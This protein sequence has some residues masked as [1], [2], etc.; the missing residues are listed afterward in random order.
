[1]RL[2]RFFSLLHCISVTK[3]R[4][5]QSIDRNLHS[6][7]SRLLFGGTPRPRA[8]RNKQ[9]SAAAAGESEN[10]PRLVGGG[11]LPRE[12]WSLDMETRLF[13]MC[14]QLRSVFNTQQR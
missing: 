9:S 5:S 12:Q 1:M 10:K 11:L 6:A 4:I 3:T 14:F 13:S 7:S 2:I 8:N